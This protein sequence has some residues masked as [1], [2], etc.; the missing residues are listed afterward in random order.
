MTEGNRGWKIR[1]CDQ[2]FEIFSFGFL[3]HGSTF[4][5]KNEF[6]INFNQMLLDQRISIFGKLIISTGYITR[7][8]LL[9]HILHALFFGF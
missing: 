4:L 1:I 3:G 8:K 2:F 7:K 9:S 5:R 6:F